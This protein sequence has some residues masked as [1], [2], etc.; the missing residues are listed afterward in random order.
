MNKQIKK[1]SIGLSLIFLLIGGFFMLPTGTEASGKSDTNDAA[2]AVIAENLPSNGM[3]V[4]LVVD[5]SKSVWEQQDKRNEA[6]RCIGN[7]A[8]GADIKI[9]CVYFADQVYSSKLD[10]TS[11]QE[12]DSAKTVLSGEALNMKERD[13]GNIDTNIGVGL[14]EARKMF[15]HN[16]INRKKAIILFS[17]GINE[18]LA[19]DPSYKEKA[20][21]LTEEQVAALKDEDVAIYC[22]YLQKGRNKESYLKKIVNYFGKEDFADGENRFKRVQEN[23]IDTLSDEFAKIF[24]AVQNGMK[25]DDSIDLSAGGKKGFYIPTM[26]VTKLQLYLKNEK[27]F[28]AVLKCLKEDSSKKES[29]QDGLN[30]YISVENPTP[31][32]WELTITGEDKEKTT[33]TIAYYTDI[34]CY[35]ELV[36]VSGDESIHK[37]SKVKIRTTFYDANGEKIDVD[38]KSTLTGIY[39]FED[40]DGNKTKEEYPLQLTE[41]GAESEEFVIGAYGTYTVGTR[42]V[43]DEYIDLNYSMPSDKITPLAPSVIDKEEIF[44]GTKTGEGIRFSIEETELVVDPEEEGIKLLSYGQ[45]NPDNKVEVKHEDGYFIVTS[46]KTGDIKFTLK[47]SDATGMTSEVTVS[48]KVRDKLMVLMI[49]IAVIICALTA[50]ILLFSYLGRKNKYKKM[51][52]EKIKQFNKKYKEAIKLQEGFSEETVDK[53][54]VEFTNLQED[55]QN[56]N[57]DEAVI[58][59]FGLDKLIDDE[60]LYEFKKPLSKILNDLNKIKKKIGKLKSSVDDIQANGSVKYLCTKCNE[61]DSAKKV[62]SEIAERLE[63]QKSNYQSE[64]QSMEQVLDDLTEKLFE[65]KDMMEE[66]ITC[67]LRVKGLTGEY[68]GTMK[69]TKA[70]RNI[71]GYYRLDEDVQLISVGGSIETLRSLGGAQMPEIIVHSYMG[72]REEEDKTGLVFRSRTPFNIKEKA[73]SDDEN[74]TYYELLKGREYK[75]FIRTVGYIIISVD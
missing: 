10:L 61:V 40:E 69:C 64:L 49:Q 74:T 67:N 59:A 55:I 30:A 12:P 21:K 57:Q 65:L 37:N 58:T 19:N 29:W 35:A 44:S 4:V 63:S 72:E 48:G 39:V 75:L 1:V 2:K 68:T 52:S 45:G 16:N 31:G 43:Y 54:T 38:E 56:C 13:L 14:R 5:N 41:E 34:K 62:I 24:Y 20:N 18:N 32:D 9:G 46:E 23:Q 22:V 6:L 8:V 26:G 53:M 42:L 11:M 33:G 25:Y 15:E 51:L 28:E 27:S 66:E 7:L 71:Q 60:G 70:G 47:V 36:S 3:D 73:D 17:D 50:I